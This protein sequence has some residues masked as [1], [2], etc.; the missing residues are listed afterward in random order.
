[1]WRA[2]EK[3]F[4]VVHF[5]WTLHQHN[6]H[7]LNS[8]VMNCYNNFKPE[9]VFMQIQREGILSIDT[10]RFM[11]QFSTTVLWNGDVRSPIPAWE[12]QLGREVDVTLFTNM[13]YVREL[14]AIGVNAQFLQVGYDDA[15]FT[16]SGTKIDSPEI[17]F[18]GSNYIDTANFPLSQLRLDMVKLLHKRYG[19]KFRVYGHNWMSH[20]GYDIFLNQ[21]QEAEAYRSCKIAINLSHF[22][23]GRYSSDRMMRMMGSGAFCLSHRFKEIEKDY[24]IGENIEIW[25]GLGNLIAKID[26]Y[27]DNKEERD[28]IRLEGLKHTKNSL[29]WNH[30]VLELKKIIDIK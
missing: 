10:V 29:T 6:H 22:D 19:E 17:I 26:Y 5:D 18:L 23:Y 28:E 25:G 16:P 8:E 15:I 2:F 11:S 14:S 24:K 1:M 27:L 13:H 30:F 7:N 20:V 3:H 9:V 12:V 4:E 21:H